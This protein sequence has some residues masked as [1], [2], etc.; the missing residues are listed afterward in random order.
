MA[1]KPQRPTYPECPTY[2]K[3]NHT[4]EKCW[5]G[6]REKNQKQNHSPDQ[7]TRCPPISMTN[8]Q[9]PHQVILSLRS[10]I[11]KT[12]FATTPI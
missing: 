10:Q 7:E 9:V 6:P 12:N 11:Q 4:A 2:S 1:K 3:T 5:K 8:S